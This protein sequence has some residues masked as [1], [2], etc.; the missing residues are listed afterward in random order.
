[1][2]PKP[3]TL[4]PGLDEFRPTEGGGD[5]ADPNVLVVV[6]YVVFWLLIAGFVALSWRKLRAIEARL[7][8]VESADRGDPEG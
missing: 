1:M 2:E 6:A 8:R 3:E 7:D 4:E 5:T